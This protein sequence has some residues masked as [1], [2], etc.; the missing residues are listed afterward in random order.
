MP[1]ANY[2]TSLLGR[3]YLPY[4]LRGDKILSLGLPVTLLCRSGFSHYLKF[5]CPRHPTP[6]KKGS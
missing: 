4:F 1:W 3:S 2:A 6:P 5:L